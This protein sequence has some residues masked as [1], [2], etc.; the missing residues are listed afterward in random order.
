MNLQYMNVPFVDKFDNNLTNIKYA[1][2]K[3]YNQ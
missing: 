1:F 2:L 3:D